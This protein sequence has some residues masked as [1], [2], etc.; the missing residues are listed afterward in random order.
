MPYWFLTPWTYLFSLYGEW[1]TELPT[2][3]NNHVVSHRQRNLRYMIRKLKQWWS[4]IHQYQQSEQPHTTVSKNMSTKYGITNTGPEL[5]HAQQCTNVNSVNRTTFWIKLTMDG[6]R[7]HNVSVV[8][9][10]LHMYRQHIMTCIIIPITRHVHV[11][12]CRC[13]TQV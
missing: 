4:T 2:E 9:H 12:H 5:G 8:G 7:Y 1:E 6:N 3:N 11:C 13:D 10:W